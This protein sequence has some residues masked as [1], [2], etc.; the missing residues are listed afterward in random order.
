TLAIASSTS[1]TERSA[2]QQ[3]ATRDACEEARSTQSHRA[4]ECED[5]GR[6]TF[7]TDAA[8]RL[9][10]RCEI[11]SLVDDREGTGLRALEHR[12]DCRTQTGPLRPRL[13]VRSK[14]PVSRVLL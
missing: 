12:P 5:V 1:L 14:S 4:R 8:A 7:A 3:V 2:P 10:R 9:R 13:L 6:H 11:D